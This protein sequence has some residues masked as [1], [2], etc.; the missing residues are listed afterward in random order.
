[1]LI[2]DHLQAVV[3]AC[4]TAIRLSRE[5]IF[6]GA[7]E[8]DEMLEK[9]KTR[10]TVPQM[11]TPD[12]RRRMQK[13]AKKAGLGIVVLA[14]EPQ[15]ALA[16]L[17]DNMAQVSV[18]KGRHLRKGD[19][20]MVA[21]LGSGTGDFVLYRLKENLSPNSR[22]ES[23]NESSGELC[24]SFLV[25]EL[26]Y[27]TLKRRKGRDWLIQAVQELK[28][29]ERDF[30]RRAL[31]AI[32]KVKREFGKDDDVGIGTIRG[33]GG[34]YRSFELTKKEI[35]AALDDVIRKIIKR[36]D[37]HVS[38]NRPDIMMI[39]GGFAKSGYLMD[40]LRQR[41][42][43]RQAIT[44]VRPNDADNDQSS[45]VAMGALIRYDNITIPALPSQYGY[46]VLRR[47]TFQANL[48]QDAYESE[49]DWETEDADRRKFVTKSWV[50]S[51]PYDPDED[52]VDDRIINIVP[53]GTKIV[54]DKTIEHKLQMEYY[55]PVDDP[56][57]T[58]EFV[59][60]DREFKDHERSRVVRNEQ[61]TEEF[62]AGIHEWA[63]VDIPLS[64]KKLKEGGFELV[65][66]NKEKHWKLNARV[67]LKCSGQ[68][69]RVGYQVL[70]PKG[71]EEGKEGEF[72][73]TEAFVV[74]DSLWEATHS[75]FLE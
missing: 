21:D 59:Y 36:I 72:K 10:I 27:L 16:Y 17:V 49:E 8:L 61:E 6:F 40:K 69:M 50:R 48:H 24:G 74:W 9:I 32:E 58:D 68:D 14:S 11:W 57:I 35:H 34:T 54:S 25:D 37:R 33:I 44:V 63:S 4:K 66:V 18:D 39:T 71:F 65:E 75:E 30:E 5:R 15:C 23:I 20:V 29:T 52:V 55:V 38:K 64:G 7:G 67:L 31:V 26:L 60:L 28:V 56:R 13:A 12:A 46:A 62:R 45:P 2:A 41:Y 42:D 43:Q 73:G 22:L 70:S 19:K 53:K 47:E 1:M 3:K 51:S